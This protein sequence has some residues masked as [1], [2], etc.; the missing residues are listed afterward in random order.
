[1][2]P[3]T[4]QNGVD[5][6]PAFASVHKK[7]KEKERLQ[8]LVASLELEQKAQEANCKQILA[9]L[10]Q[11]RDTIIQSKRNLVV[12]FLQTCIF[13]RCLFSASD[14]IFCARFA[15]LM[16]DLRAKNWST[17]VYM[18]RIFASIACTVSSCTSNEAQR[19]GRFIGET[20][21]LLARWHGSKDIFDKE[22]D[23]H[24]SFR[25]DLRVGG[26]VQ[27]A[28]ITYENFRHLCYQWHQRLTKATIFLLDSGEYVLQK[29]TLIILRMVSH[30]TQ[31][32]RLRDARSNT[33]VHISFFTPQP[34]HRQSC[35]RGSPL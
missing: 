15:Q 34:L 23:D 7:R 3:R 8:S 35:F 17:L 22:C 26:V 14:A 5:R 27:N 24:P 10:H 6:D 25:E 1:M 18:D 11:E 12:N 2:L 13:P 21:A 32:L 20:L 28:Q 16:H 30:I 19:Y 29:N 9:R 4:L 31:R 33:H